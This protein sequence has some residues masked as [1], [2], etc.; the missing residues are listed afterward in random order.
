M[1]GSPTVQ[2]SLFEENTGCGMYN[3]D[4]TVMVKRCV[5]R[6]NTRG[7][8]R[9]EFT[10]ERRS[11]VTVESCLFSDNLAMGGIFS[12]VSILTEPPAALQLRVTNSVFMR[13]TAPV[14]GGL[15]DSGSMASITNCTITQNTVFGYGSD[16][17]GWGGGFYQDA[18]AVTTM[19]NCIF[20]GNTAAQG[21]EVF[22]AA[23]TLTARYSCIPAG[24]GDVGTFY[25]NPLFLDPLNKDVR[26]ETGSPCI[27][28]GTADDAPA[29]D[30]TG[31]PRPQGAGVDIGAYER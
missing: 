23:G 19:T 17:P 29:T 12:S 16:A 6:G 10:A 4:A 26:V 30:I 15:Y 20:W 8:M 22:V 25:L 5:F 27:D 3:A 1:G 24:F 18:N 21:P 31:R 28:T 14:G 2:D 9:N 11:L 13:N 7:G